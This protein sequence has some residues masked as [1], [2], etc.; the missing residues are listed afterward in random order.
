MIEII[1]IT[2]KDPICSLPFLPLPR[3]LLP[4]H[5]QSR[6]IK[7]KSTALVLWG[8][9]IFSRSSSVRVV[10]ALPVTARRS[11]TAAAV[12]CPHALKYAPTCET[13]Q[14]R[15]SMRSGRPTFRILTTFC[16]RTDTFC[17]TPCNCTIN[18]PVSFSTDKIRPSSPF[19]PSCLCR[20]TTLTRSPTKALPP[21]QVPDPQARHLLPLCQI[22]LRAPDQSVSTPLLLQLQNASTPLI[23]QL[24]N[25]AE[26]EESKRPVFAACT[27][28]LPSHHTHTCKGSSHTTAATACLICSGCCMMRD[29]PRNRKYHGR[30]RCHHN[31][32]V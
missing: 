2:R 9:P 24:Q 14:A 11:K 12:P 23:L 6:W 28:S 29:D 5:S 15:G 26:S 16:G 25:A 10:K 7:F 4:F 20:P 17:S 18:R 8:M 31:R 3:H 21:P 32:L 27:A 22:L 13:V 19:S 1:K 30:M